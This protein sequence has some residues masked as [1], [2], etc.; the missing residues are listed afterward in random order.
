MTV[1]DIPGVVAVGLGG[2]GVPLSP[3]FPP[4][5]STVGGIQLTR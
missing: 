1:F 2:A 3:P 5:F 4:P